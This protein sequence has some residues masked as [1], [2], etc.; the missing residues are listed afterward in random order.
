MMCESHEG[1]ETPRVD[2]IQAYLIYS[3]D[4]VLCTCENAGKDI[5][6]L[7]HNFHDDTNHCTHFEVLSWFGWKA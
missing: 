2:G 1:F 5:G 6:H 3:V 7:A 4:L